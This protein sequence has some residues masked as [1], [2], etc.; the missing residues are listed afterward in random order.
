VGMKMIKVIGETRSRRRSEYGV[1]G[2]EQEG[3]RR[4]RRTRR[5]KS[6]RSRRRMRSRKRTRSKRTKGRVFIKV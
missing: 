2:K 3:T 1:G 4:T 6:R 5:T